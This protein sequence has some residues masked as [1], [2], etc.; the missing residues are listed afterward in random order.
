MR[1]LL[2]GLFLG[3]TLFASPAS[4][5]V[6]DAAACLEA[7]DVVCAR[8]ALKSLNA[9]ESESAD[10]LLFEA[11]AAFYAGEY[12]NAHETLIRALE[13]GAKD[14]YDDLGLYERTLA[15]TQDFLEVRRGNFVVR[16]R[17]GLDAVLVDGAIESMEKA[18]RYLAPL[19]GGP[20][21]GKV[22]LEIFPHA[23]SFTMA[24]SLSEQNVRTTGVIAL[25]KWSRLLMVSPRT[26]GGGFTWEDTIAHEYIHLVVSHQTRDRSPVWLQEGIA[27]FLDNRW[28]DG[29]DRFH[30][31]PR[32]ESILAKA[33]ASGE[34]VT[35]EQ[36]H[37][38]LAKLPS[39][40][41]A[42]LAY[43]QLATLLAFSFEKGGEDVLLRVLPRVKT[44]EDPRQVLAEESGFEDLETMVAQWKTWVVQAGLKDRG[45]KG[46]PVV[47]DPNDPSEADPVLSGR[48]DLANFMRLG[49]LLHER[50]HYKA[51]LIEYAKAEGADAMGSPLLA[52]RIATTQIAMGQWDS[53]AATIKASL[54]AYPEHADSHQLMG[55]IYRHQ[56]KR[57][58]A[59]RAYSKALSMYP[60]D[61]ASQEALTELY[62]AAGDTERAKRHQ[63]YLNILRRGGE[64]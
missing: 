25:S 2:G 59:I 19:M 46:K 33:I 62:T 13:A 4:A 49:D 39:A 43:A 18:Q 63:R 10:A 35:F 64:G 30:L 34:L 57:I 11:R 14:P 40:D 9:K 41:M 29:K 26:L 53:A 44:G 48:R 51:A 56:G 8:T 31:E 20:P 28:R 6:A 24:S 38:S 22:M 45:V 21:P 15:A 1:A 32:L 12:S 58:E 50:K 3:G 27:K 54:V 42:G 16:Y 36:M 52:S 37:P 17:P 55:Q 61:S 5:S 60:F 47:L 7:A 23:R